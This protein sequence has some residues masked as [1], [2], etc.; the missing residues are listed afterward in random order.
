VGLEIIFHEGMHQWDDQVF[1]ALRAQAGKV[2]KFFPRGL[3]HALVFFTAGKRFAG[4]C[5]VHEPYAEKFGIWQRGLGPFKCRWMRF[6]SRIS[7]V[8]VFATMRLPSSSNAP[9]PPKK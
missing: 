9:E 6:G 4:P 1:E 3:D 2:K 8:A 7:M 5:Q